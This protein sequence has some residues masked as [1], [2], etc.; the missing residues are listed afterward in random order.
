MAHLGMTWLA[1]ANLPKQY[2]ATCGRSTIIEY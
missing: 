2:R 1:V